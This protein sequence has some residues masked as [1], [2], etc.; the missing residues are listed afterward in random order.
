MGD[1]TYCMIKKNSLKYFLDIKP[2]SSNSSSN[3]IVARR[4]NRRMRNNEACR[5]YRVA[6]RK[7]RAFINVAKKKSRTPWRASKFARGIR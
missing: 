7:T 4:Q 5:K 1:K 2:T 3:P 6:P